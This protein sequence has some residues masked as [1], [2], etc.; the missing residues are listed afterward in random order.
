M[1]ERDALGLIF[2][3][4]GAYRDEGAID[5]SSKLVSVTDKQHPR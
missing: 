5:I 2:E 1:G 3:I 4:I